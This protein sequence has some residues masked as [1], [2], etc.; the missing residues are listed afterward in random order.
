MRWTEGEPVVVK[1]SEVRFGVNYVP[2]K[3][4]W[5]SWQDWSIQSIEEDLQSIAF[6]GF[7]HIRIHCLW[8]YFQPN[9]TMVSETMLHRLQELLHVASRARIDVIVTVFNGWLSGFDFRPAWLFDDGNMFVDEKAI[10]AQLHLLSALAET[11]GREHNFVGFDIG[12]EPSVLTTDEKNSCATLQG[13]AWVKRLTEHCELIA[14]GK[15]HCVGMDHVPWLTDEKPF[16]RS[17]LANEANITPLHAWIYFT[18]ALDRYGEKGTGTIY[19]AAYMLELAKAY[20]TDSRRLVW[21]QEFGVAPGWLQTLAA[22][23]FL[24]SVTRSIWHQQGLWGI[25]W[26]ASHD[27]SRSLTGFAELEYDLGLLT[28]DNTPKQTALRFRDLISEFKAGEPR[29]PAVS[30]IALVLPRSATPDL[31]FADAFF[32]QID[33]GVRPAIV[34]EQRSHDSVYLKSRG[35]E[36]LLEASGHN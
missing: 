13:D 2:R 3:G 35:I 1:A 19:L 31:S 27:I 8:P 17:I 10:D 25:T 28:V 32:A 34:L 33:Q 11:I 20:H 9:P 22:E 4:W 23:D 5:Y 21:L 12:N 24:E 16:S 29:E 6:L 15:I 7:D 14:P 30:T 18:G 36:R 26:W